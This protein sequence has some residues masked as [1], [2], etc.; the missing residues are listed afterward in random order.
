MLQCHPYPHEYVDTSRPCAHCAFFMGLQRKEGVRGQEGQQFDIRGTV[1]EFRQD[2]NMYLFWKP[3]MDIYVSHVRRKQLPSFVFPDGYKRPRLSRH[4]SP[5][6]KKNSEGAAACQPFSAEK[7]RKIDS[8]EADVK[9]I[10]PEKRISVSPQ[11]QASA[12]PERITSRPTGG[13]LASD[14]HIISSLK[15]PVSVCVSNLSGPGNEVKRELEGQMESAAVRSSEFKE[16]HQ[17]GDRIGNLALVNVSPHAKKN[18]EDSA[19]SRPCSAEKKRKSDTETV[20]V[21]LSKSEKRPCVSP[22]RQASVSPEIITGTNDARLKCSRSGV[23]NLSSENRSFC[24]PKASERYIIRNSGEV[25]EN[26]NPESI[27]PNEPAST[28][29]C[30]S[31]GPGNDATAVEQLGRMDSALSCAVHC[32]EFKEPHRNGGRVGNLTSVD[33]ACAESTPT[34]RLLNQTENAVDDERDMSKPCNQTTMIENVEQ[35]FKS[36][37]CVKNLNC[38]VSFSI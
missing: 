2:V 17:N 38:E 15:G 19:G 21:K 13:L 20:D 34:G 9:P 24:G 1:D 33:V 28:C 4:V 26:T 16:R 23:A 8:E 29:V 27:S 32:S 12:S 25:V 14:A 5:Q 36:S 7:K 22:Q 35:A 30:N 6:A 31:P 18:N 10:K 11:H 37:S 3:G